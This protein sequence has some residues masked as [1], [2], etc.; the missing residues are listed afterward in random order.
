MFSRERLKAMGM[1]MP[2][3]IIMLI[4]AMLIFGPKKLPEMGSAIGRSI[5]AFSKGMHEISNPESQELA[6]STPQDA[7]AE[8]ENNEENQVKTASPRTEASPEKQAD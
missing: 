7:L 5:Q 1:H 3:L 2:E 8:P 4:V 6:E